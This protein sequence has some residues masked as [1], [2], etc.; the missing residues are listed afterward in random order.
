MHKAFRPKVVHKL[1]HNFQKNKISQNQKK[2]ENCYEIKRQSSF[3]RKRKATEKTLAINL[4]FRGISMGRVE[5]R[6]IAIAKAGTEEE[7]YPKADSKPKQRQ[8]RKTQ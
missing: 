4:S 5:N 7:S 2:I 1:V 8:Q 6:P 3:P